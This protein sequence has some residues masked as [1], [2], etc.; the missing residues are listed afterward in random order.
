MILFHS[1]TFFQFRPNAHPSVRTVN[2]HSPMLTVGRCCACPAVII[3][4]RRRRVSLT[5]SI[6]TVVLK[7]LIH[8]QLRRLEVISPV[9]KF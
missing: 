3:V 1:T 5:A 6:I 2:R 7:R 8:I 4:R 9:F